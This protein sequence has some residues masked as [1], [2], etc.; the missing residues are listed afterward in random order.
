MILEQTESGLGMDFVGVS[1]TGVF[2]SELY[3]GGVA[4]LSGLI[5]RGDQILR[6]NQHDTGTTV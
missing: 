4:L 1:S 2:V 3:P 6:L 5:H